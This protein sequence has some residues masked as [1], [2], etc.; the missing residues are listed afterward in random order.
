MP[1]SNITDR[2]CHPL[3]VLLG[4]AEARAAG[5]RAGEYSLEEA[6]APLTRFA[7]R[8][9][10]LTRFDKLAVQKIIALPFREPSPGGRA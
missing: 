1:Q 9:P 5:Y 7:V 3:I 2:S 6:L 8:N 4:W 10:A